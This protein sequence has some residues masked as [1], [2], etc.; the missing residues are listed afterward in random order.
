MGPAGIDRGKQRRM[1]SSR[2]HQRSTNTGPTR[3]SS[4]RPR[5]RW[6][7]SPLGARRRAATRT[8]APGCG[9]PWA[10]LPLPARG[11]TGAWSTGGGPTIGSWI[12]SRTACGS[13]LTMWFRMI[14]TCAAP[15]RRLLSTV[16]VVPAA[17]HVLATTER[18]FVLKQHT[19]VV[20]LFFFCTA[21]DWFS[22]QC[23]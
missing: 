17:I 2:D 22:A 23:A 7:A 1:N 16:D 10:A 13:A 11:W 4:A 9:S 3:S 6:S 15:P 12:A 14:P 5:M 20:H 21:I 19:V 18:G 8:A